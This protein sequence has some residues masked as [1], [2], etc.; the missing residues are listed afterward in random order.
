MRIK[1]VAVDITCDRLCLLLTAG[2][3]GWFCQDLVL[4]GSVPFF[5]DLSTYFYPLRFILFE[6]YRSGNLPLWDRQVAMGFPVLA[7]FQSG[8]FYPPH[9]L[10]LV[11]PLFTAIRVI[12]IF[13]FVIAATGTYKLFRS[14]DY[15]C[16][17]SILGSLLFALGG[18]VV[19][20]SN[21]LNHFQAAVWLPWVILFWENA[22]R[23]VSWKNFLSFVLV[24]VVQFVAGSP[25]LFA[26]SMAL[27]LIDGLGIKASM[28]AVSYRKMIGIFICAN[29]LVIAVCMVQVLPTVELFLESRRQQPIP[30]QE[31]LYWSLNPW[32][33]FNLIFLDKE[34][35]SSASIGMRLF[36]ARESTYFVSYYLGAVSVL[37]VCIWLCL[38]RLRH[39]LTLLWLV[40]ASLLIALGSYTPIYPF[41]LSQMPILGSIRFPEK[42]FFFSYAL[43]VYMAVKGLAKLLDCDKI[44]FKRSVLAFS[45]ICVAWVGVYL[46][47][48]SNLGMVGRLITVGSGVH[49]SSDLYGKMIAAVLA[50]LERQIILCIALLLLFV[51]AKTEKIRR[52]IFV[53]LIV[54]VTVVDLSWAHRGFLFPLNPE[55]IYKSARILQKPDRDQNRLFYY[56]S[57]RNLHPNSFLVQAQ[58]PFKEATALFVQNLL[59]NEGIFHGFE[60]FQEIDALAR[61]PYTEFLSFANQ[62]ALAEQVRLLRTFN[63]GYL[64]SFQPLSAE[65]ITFV[66]HYPQYFSWLY[67]IDKPIPRTY[68]VNKSSV[69][70]ASQQILRRLLEPSFDP[71]QEVV[72][73]QGTPI[74]G[75]HRLDATAKIV[76]Y[77]DQR[78]I[79]ETSLNDAGIL[80]LADSYYPGWK[81]Y[82]DG[83]EETIRRAN[84]FFRAVP[85]SAGDHKVEFRYEPRSFTI[86][87]GISISTVFAIVMISAVCH[88]RH[89]QNHSYSGFLKS[90]TETSGTPAS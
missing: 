56:P 32:R 8:A 85:L 57:G 75:K 46:Y 83:K 58:P 20:L 86:G 60:Y 19:S 29:L 33:L 45:A 54:F 70:Q 17:S 77:K 3:V 35:D 84:L 66:R 34:V 79:V 40:L 1:R 68:I 12:Y 73:D 22:V 72:L 65:G 2:L 74:Q 11:F 27:V 53:L 38:D 62:L 5:R 61:W 16:Y 28:P 69:E 48:Q 15:P 55:F 24:M 87:C 43:F 9:L 14:W 50:N 63:V 76:D 42:F 49:P 51:L 47:F 88:L 23:T 89:R 67:K 80:V 18:T 64:I 36:F 31:A 21:L 44:T 7:D 6:N 81:A 41:L 30:V 82:I 90:K 37:G 78:V 26:F 59:P 13:H 25:E 4:S 52:G 10:F 39:K 71:A